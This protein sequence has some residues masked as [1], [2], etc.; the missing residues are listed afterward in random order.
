MLKA[1]EEAAL[2][3][4]MPE[5]DSFEPAS[6]DGIEY[7]TAA[8]DGT[9]R[10]YCVRVT[11]GGYNGYIRIIAGVDVSGVI[12]GVRVLEHQETPGLGAKISEVRPGDKDPWFLRQFA[13]KQAASLQV[14]RNIDAIT[15]ATISSAAV[16]DA[17]RDTVK[18]L[19]EKVKK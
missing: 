19:M 1:E 12:R 17:V 3:V 15:G 9:L 10:G 4:V 18:R 14:R 11:A 13:G 8:K 5:A 6:A 16:T 2:K 7:F